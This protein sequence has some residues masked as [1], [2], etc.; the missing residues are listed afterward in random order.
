LLKEMAEGGCSLIAFLAARGDPEAKG[1][2]AIAESLRR[3][4]AVRLQRFQPIVD[5]GFQ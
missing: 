1:V 2:S 3:S 5:P 4:F